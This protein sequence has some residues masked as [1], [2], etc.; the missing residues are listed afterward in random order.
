MPTRAA[1]KKKKKNEPLKKEKKEKNQF[2][3]GRRKQGIIAKLPSGL[4]RL[5]VCL[6]FDGGK[7]ENRKI[8]CL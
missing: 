5:V 1:K 8:K 6:P 3:F 7:G 2:A 4:V